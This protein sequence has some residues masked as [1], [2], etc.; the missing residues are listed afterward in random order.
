M[1]DDL[2]FDA[3]RKRLYA[4]CGDGFLA[5]IEKTGDKYEVTAKIETAKKAETSAFNGTL[6]R[7]CLGAPCWTAS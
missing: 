2:H 5:V 1:V 4:S 3:K 7:P 6:G